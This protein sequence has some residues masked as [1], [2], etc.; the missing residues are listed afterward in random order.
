VTIGLSKVELAA[1]CLDPLVMRDRRG[2]GVCRRSF[3]KGMVRRESPRV[4]A[5]LWQPHSI[6]V[7]SLKGGSI[8]A[9]TSFVT[10]G[11]FPS[12]GL[13][14]ELPDAQQAVIE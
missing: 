2:D 7:L 10:P 11:L 3:V 1:T 6:Q 12:F 5:R 8:S 14:A 9:M 13:S 4:Q